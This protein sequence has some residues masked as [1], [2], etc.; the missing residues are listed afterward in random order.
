MTGGYRRIKLFSLMVALLVAGLAVVG[1]TWATSTSLNYMPG[2]TASPLDNDPN[3]FGYNVKL[4][5]HNGTDYVSAINENVF[6]EKLWC[7]GKTEVVYLRIKNN[8]PF[9]VDVSLVMDRNEA[10][11]TKLGEV[12]TAAW[13]KSSTTENLKEHV[14]ALGSWNEFC[15]VA[16]SNN[17]QM[18]TEDVTILE[19]GQNQNVIQANQSIDVVLAIHMDESASSEYA[20]LG[21]ELNFILNVNSDEKPSSTPLAN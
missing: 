2:E 3:K 7:P 5:Y 12:L 4:L 15:I 10:K 20:A 1:G 6:A 9:P 13:I 8:E 19:N 21:I 18:L 14:K 17:I 11:E 16:T